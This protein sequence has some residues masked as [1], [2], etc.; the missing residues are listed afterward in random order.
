MAEFTQENFET[1]LVDKS[2]QL[3]KKLDKL[4]KPNQEDGKGGYYDYNEGRELVSSGAADMLKQII[5]GHLL[6][7]EPDWKQATILLSLSQL[8]YEPDEK[9]K[10]HEGRNLAFSR[11]VRSHKCLLVTEDVEYQSIVMRYLRYI[12][13]WIQK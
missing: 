9:I 4:Y 12:N 10:F 6:S 3:A 5:N 8:L 1:L 11:F 7:S 13:F 2:F